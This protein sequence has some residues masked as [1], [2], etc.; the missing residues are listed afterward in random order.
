[1]KKGTL[2]CY[3]GEFEEISVQV[4]VDPGA[5][6]GQRD[7]GAVPP[8]RQVLVQAEA[9]TS[10][11]HLD[12]LSPGERASPPGVILHQHLGVSDTRDEGEVSCFTESFHRFWVKLRIIQQQ[13]FKHCGLM[14]ILDEDWY[15]FHLSAFSG[16]N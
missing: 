1:M 16:K 9:Q 10:Q 14:G 15:Q 3:G 12:R 6:V 8:H 13:M 2:T 11:P 4:D 7:A 5:V